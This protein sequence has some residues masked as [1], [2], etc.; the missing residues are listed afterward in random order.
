MN[1]VKLCKLLE[2]ALEI[3]TEA[4]DPVL[5]KILIAASEL[6]D[7]MYPEQLLDRLNDLRQDTYIEGYGRD[8]SVEYE[9][10]ARGEVVLWHNLKDSINRWSKEE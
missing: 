9:P 6:A 7:E 2:G 1:G 5:Y 10:S 3:V 8:A 4:S